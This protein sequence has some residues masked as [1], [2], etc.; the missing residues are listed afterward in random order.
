MVQAGEGGAIINV[1]SQMGRIGAPIRT[2]YCATKH[3]VEGMTK[4]MAVEL[5]LYDVRVNALA[6]TYIHTPLTKPM[7]EDEAFLA[8]TLS[9]IPMGRIGQIEDLMGAVV[10]LASPAAAMVT[11]S[12]S[13]VDG[14][15]TAQ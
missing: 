7:F 13:L 11:G 1:S 4:A 10:F 5:A 2:V 9:R 14:G 3:A 12:S 15:Y 8:D 6:P